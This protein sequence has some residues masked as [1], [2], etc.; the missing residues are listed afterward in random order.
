LVEH[1]DFTLYFSSN[2]RTV[3]PVVGAVHFEISDKS[4]VSQSG[5]L[6]NVPCYRSKWPRT[7]GSAEEQETRAAAVTPV[8]KIW[9]SL[10]VH[11]VK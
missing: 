10:L 5:R 11:F 1:M 7:V 8:A 9:E 2:S 4:S 3:V 6:H